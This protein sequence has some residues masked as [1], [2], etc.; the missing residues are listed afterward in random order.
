MPMMS[1]THS[2][3]KQNGYYSLQTAKKMK[4]RPTAFKYQQL[5]L[6]LTFIIKL[7][8][9]KCMYIPCHV[10]ITLSCSLRKAFGIFTF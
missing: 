7:Q 4:T 5:A 1:H 6:N 8:L 9:F 10:Q 3:W 2:S